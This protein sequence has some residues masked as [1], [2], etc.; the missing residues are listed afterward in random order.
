MSDDLIVFEQRDVLGKDFKIYG[1]P[2]NPLFLAKDVADW[3]D[4]DPNKVNDMVT[5]VDDHEKLTETISWSGQG[6]K[7]WFLT[8]DGLYEVLFQSRK[9]IA[10]EFKR[11]VK[12]IL[13]EIRRRGIYVTDVALENMLS[14]PDFGIRLLSE[15]KSEREKIAALEQKIEVDKPK[16]DFANALEATKDTIYIGD[17]A[18]LLQKN[19]TDIGQTRLFEWLR[20]NGYLMSGFSRNTPTQRSLEAG[21]LV[22]KED[23]FEFPN[24]DVRISKTAMVT[25]KGQAYFMNLFAKRGV[26][27]EQA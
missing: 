8:E 10:K 5:M 22:I 14:S 12:Q 24:G 21:L 23:I 27:I 26:S 3:I 1:D 20:Q 15:I 9:P 2:E 4:Y 16:V 7:M 18:K 11:Q 19:G 17:L 13:K 6:R 25:V